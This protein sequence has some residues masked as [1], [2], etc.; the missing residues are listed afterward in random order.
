MNFGRLSFSDKLLRLITKSSFDFK[1]SFLPISVNSHEIEF[2]PINQFISVPN[3]SYSFFI[4]SLSYRC[5]L[6]NNL[7]IIELSNQELILCN[8]GNPAMAVAALCVGACLAAGQ[9]G[10]AV[11]RAIYHLFN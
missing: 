3:Q 6:K 11:G 10:E 9:L 8:G 5:A 7:G 1:V 2:K 4:Y